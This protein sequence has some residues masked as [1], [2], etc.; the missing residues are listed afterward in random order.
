MY[1]N[2]KY[3]CGLYSTEAILQRSIML[4]YYVI[5]TYMHRYKK[6]CD[7]ICEKGSYTR[8]RFCNFDEA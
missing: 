1:S 7:W 5:H 8:I 3:V 4:L 6:I 2:N